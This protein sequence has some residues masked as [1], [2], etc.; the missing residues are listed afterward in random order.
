MIIK[1]QQQSFKKGITTKL[2]FCLMRLAKKKDN[3]LQKMGAYLA[4]RAKIR[5]VYL[6]KKLH[7]PK[8]K[9]GL[10]H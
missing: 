5:E 9:I 1:L 8:I 2:P 10:C 6:A 4:L 7:Y 3:P